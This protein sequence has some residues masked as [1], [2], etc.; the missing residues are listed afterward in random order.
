MNQDLQKFSDL[1]EKDTAL[2]EKI[3]AAA[4]NY[5]GEKTVANVSRLQ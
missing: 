2:Q 5:T 3:K 4:E 1:L